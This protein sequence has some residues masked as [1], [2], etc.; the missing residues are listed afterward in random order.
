MRPD[1]AALFK[2]INIF[3]GKL[4]L[5]AARVVLF[6][7]I[8]EMQRAGEAC[9]ARAH[10]QYIR[11]ELFALYGHVLFILANEARSLDSGQTRPNVGMP[12]RGLMDR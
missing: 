3:S 6:N 11:F 9:R 5:G 8:R 4:G 2:H 12:V 10:N 1:F 7:E